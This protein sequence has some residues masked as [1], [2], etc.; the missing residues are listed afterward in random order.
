[1]QAGGSLKVKRVVANVR[2]A[3]PALAE[4]FYAD[5]L[6]LD[7]L[8]DMNWIRT[9]GSKTKMS[10]QVSFLSEGGSGTPV[11]DLSIEVDDLDIAFNKFKKGGFDI[12][13]GPVGEPWGVRRFF[14]R[15][16]FGR[17]VNVLSHIDA[18]EQHQ[19]SGGSAA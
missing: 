15:D 17:L 4:K 9:Y 14:V 10:V 18:S 7:L 16:P 5:I 11:P 19:T 12:E 2:A 6:G 1:V 3:D 8:M 13:Y